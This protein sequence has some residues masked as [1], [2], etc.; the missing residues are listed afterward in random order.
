[1][2]PSIDMNTYQRDNMQKRGNQQGNV[3]PLNNQMRPMN[4]MGQQPNQMQMGQQPNQMQMGPMN[5]RGPS[6]QRGPMNQ[7]DQ[8]M[9]M[10]NMRP[11]QQ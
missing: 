6:N 11:F 8:Q 3:R 4:Q 1:M 9:Q 2:L 7:R 5:Q 10:R